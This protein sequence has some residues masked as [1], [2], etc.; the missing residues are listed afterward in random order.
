[1]LLLM[2][3]QVDDTAVENLLQEIANGSTK[4]LEQL[5]RKTDKAIYAYA[6][7]ILRNAQDSEDVLQECFIR[8]FR[9]AAFYHDDGK[10]MA[11]ILT[12][13]KNLCMDLIRNRSRITDL[14]DDM[15]LNLAA[16]ET[17]YEDRLVLSACMQTL[18][19][20]ERQIVV[21]HAVAGFK[22]RQI[23]EFLE[24]SLT[25]VLSKYHRAIRKMKRRV[26]E[27]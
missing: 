2:T 15:W 10:P 7:S 20:K 22:H 13:A 4:A 21:L 3:L 17:T 27:P 8:I 6:L 25:G 26:Q 18:S 9:S 12:I 11:W 5:Y 14:P 16:P 19:D 24:M 23:A 1:M